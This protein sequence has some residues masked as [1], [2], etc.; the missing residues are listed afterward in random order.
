MTIA[1][2]EN[3]DKKRIPNGEPCLPIVFDVSV[4]FGFYS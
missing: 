4:A 3:Y 2:P 1:L